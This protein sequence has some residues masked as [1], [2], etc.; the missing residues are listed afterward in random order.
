LADI[1]GKKLIGSLIKILS[2]VYLWTR[3]SLLILEVILI[4]S[5]DMDLD[6]DRICLVEVCAAQ[7][8]LFSLH[9]Y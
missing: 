4:W 7:V 1:S 3:K 5:P 2:Q 6:P 8:L 9:R